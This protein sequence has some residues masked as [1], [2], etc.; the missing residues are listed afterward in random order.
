M[1]NKTDGAP[2]FEQQLARLG[3]IVRMLER[4]DAPLADSLG[5]FEEGAHLA[6]ECTRQL[7]EAEQRVVKL[8]SLIHISLPGQVPAQI[9]GTRSCAHELR[10]EHTSLHRVRADEGHQSL[11]A[12]CARNIGQNERGY[13][14]L[15]RKLY[16]TSTR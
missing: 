10:A 16:S 11:G 9:F 2:S 5:L 3:E 13:I 12:L 1:D 8:L 6:A 14:C 15:R 7:D 4:G